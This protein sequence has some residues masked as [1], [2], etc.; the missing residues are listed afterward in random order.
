MSNLQFDFPSNVENRIHIFSIIIILLQVSHYSLK[1][2]S[3]VMI[4]MNKMLF[5]EKSFILV[6]LQIV[7][8]TECQNDFLLSCQP[9][10]NV[11]SANYEC[12]SELEGP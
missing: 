10:L 2:K 5:F 4:T 7:S 1:G 11:I 3:M 9:R 12:Y 6:F 8:K